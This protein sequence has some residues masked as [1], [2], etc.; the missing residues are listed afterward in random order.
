MDWSVVVMG[1]LLVFLGFGC[2]WW[3][4]AKVRKGASPRQGVR[5]YLFSLLI[6]LGM[7]VAKSPHLVGAPFAVVM[8]A[9]SL[10]L[11]LGVAAALVLVVPARRQVG[12]GPFAE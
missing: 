1:C 8:T 9:D 2:R 3:E 7:I 4:Q 12:S 11:V 10:S 6:G 5:L